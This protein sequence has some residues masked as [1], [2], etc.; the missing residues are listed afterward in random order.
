MS[1]MRSASV[2][3]M[4]IAYGPH[5][6]DWRNR[7]R[8]RER[9]KFERI[10]SHPPVLPFSPGGGCRF[11]RGNALLATLCGCRGGSSGARDRREV[12]PIQ[13]GIEHHVEFA[14]VLPAVD[15]VVGEQHHASLA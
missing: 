4:R 9:G 7:G 10:L 1:S 11:K 13:H 12:V 2:R 3:V 8:R 6:R 5:A 15:W 14:V